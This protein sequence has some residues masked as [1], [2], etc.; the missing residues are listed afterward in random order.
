MTCVILKELT[1]KYPIIIN[2]VITA[3]LAIV[4]ERERRQEEAR[5]DQNIHQQP[6]PEQDLL[7]NPQ[8]A[9]GGLVHRR[10]TIL[11]LS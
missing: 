6:D 7:L 2:T 4:L 9:V 11:A 5:N 8:Q 1:T 3:A 10:Y